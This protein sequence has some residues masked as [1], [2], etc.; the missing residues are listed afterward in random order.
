MEILKQLQYSPMAVQNQIAILFCG[1][2]NLLRDVP[3]KKVHDFQENYLSIMQEKYSDVLDELK[4]GKLTD[5][6]I[7]TMKEVT[8]GISGRYKK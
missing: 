7:E 1:A 4:D 2:N 5:K 8:A 3:V 6:A